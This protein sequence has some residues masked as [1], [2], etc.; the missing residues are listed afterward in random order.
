MYEE[1][2][3]SIITPVFNDEK[4]ISETLKSILFQTHSNLEII[5][6]NDHSNDKSEEI[7]N[8]FIDKRIKVI[9][10]DTNRG[11]AFSR[12]IALS[13]ATGEYIAFL[14]GDDIWCK[15][16]IEKQL[17]FM[18]ENNVE[19]SYTNYEEIDEEGKRTGTLITGPAKIT[20]SKMKRACYPG[21]LTVMYKRNIFPDLSIPP[22]MKKRNDYAMWLLL[23]KKATCCL[24]NETLAF[25]RKRSNSISSGKKSRLFKYHV[26]VFCK[27]LNYSTFR[28]FVYALLNVFFYFYRKHK[29]RKTINIK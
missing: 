17:T 28:S 22:I 7:I 3:V 21:C 1:V 24:L 20:F 13:K 10:N 16:K 11:T 14:D 26:I 15:T 25:Y 27:V 6:V 18:I 4:Y 23:S 12:N 19:F 29:Y 5:I 9:N 8:S 2:K